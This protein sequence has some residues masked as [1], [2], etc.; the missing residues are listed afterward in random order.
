MKKDN[1][2]TKWTK[3]QD[4]ILTGMMLNRYTYEEAG[5]R[6]RRTP[7]AVEFRWRQINPQRKRVTISSKNGKPKNHG[8]TWSERDEQILQDMYDAGHSY[9][10]IA[11]SLG[12]KE[13][14]VKKHHS[15]IRLGG[16]IDAPG[17]LT[18]KQTVVKKDIGYAASIALVISS[19]IFL[20][21]ALSL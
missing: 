21:A 1:S 14:S 9:A 16:V 11:E 5:E 4:E 19:L 7:G 8:F 17:H 18:K 13:S 3:Y 2:H 10:E 12:R 15:R 20:L 6:L